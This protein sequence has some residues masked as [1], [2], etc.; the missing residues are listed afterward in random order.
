VAAGKMDRDQTENEARRDYDCLYGHLV[1]L[2][3]DTAGKAYLMRCLERLYEWAL[4]GVAAEKISKP[5]CGQ[6]AV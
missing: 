1:G 2:A 5:A 6:D 4:V 3:T